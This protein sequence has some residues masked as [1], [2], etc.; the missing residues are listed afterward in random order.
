METIER[1]G[2]RA[3]IEQDCDPLHPRKDYD[4]A[5]TML[6]Y[7]DRYNLGD[8]QLNYCPSGIRN[9]LEEAINEEHTFRHAHSHGYGVDV[10]ELSDDHIEA[11]MDKHFVWLPLWLYDHSGLAMS[12]G[13]FGY[14]SMWDCGCVG[15]IYMYKDKVT[16]EF[17]SFGKQ[18]QE[19]ALALMK[20][21]V[22]EYSQYLEGDVWQYAI[23]DK[24]GDCVDS[25]C[26][27]YGYD[28]AEKEVEGMLDWYCENHPQEL[29]EE[30]EEVE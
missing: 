14:H 16:E 25:C 2:Y 21:E 3:V 4:P 22:K 29:E 5:A 26:G 19:K 18:A 9:F 11:I 17:G 30:E 1:G 8:K 7:H 20:A 24:D 6:C 10:E 15:I 27:F 13:R 12:T 23:Y 28:Y